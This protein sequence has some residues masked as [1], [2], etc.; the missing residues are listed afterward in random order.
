ML[1]KDIE[2]VGSELALATKEGPNQGQQYYVHSFL[3]GTATFNVIEYKNEYGLYP[4]KS[5]LDSIGA[6]R[7]KPVTAIFD[8]YV[9][10]NGY[11]SV[12]LN[13]IERIIE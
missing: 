10:M 3:L 13:S 9:N 2:Y 12:K 4:I 5:A 8:L 11:L 1:K 6:E 7:L